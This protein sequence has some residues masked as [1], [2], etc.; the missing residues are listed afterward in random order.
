[1][2]HNRN[3]LGDIFD[4]IRSALDTAQTVKAQVDAVR[5]GD[6][7]ITTV[8]SSGAYFSI[9]LPGQPIAG[10]VP[11]W[12]IGFGVSLAAFLLLKKSR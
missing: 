4:D 2:Y 5:S 6:R 7:K 12:V 9:P 3:G 11:F 1:M 10:T 8:P